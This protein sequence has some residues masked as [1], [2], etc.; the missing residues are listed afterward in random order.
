MHK[1]SDGSTGQQFVVIKEVIFTTLLLVTSWPTGHQ[2]ISSGALLEINA[3]CFLGLFVLPFHG[4]FEREAC[5]WTSLE[6][7]KHL[8]TVWGEI[9]KIK[10]G[11]GGSWDKQFT[12]PPETLSFDKPGLT[13]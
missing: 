4:S 6:V 1:S 8:G 3:F 12:L 5:A 10:M 11:R 13:V 9:L 2:Q 7:W